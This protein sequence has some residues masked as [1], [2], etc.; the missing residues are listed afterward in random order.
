MTEPTPDVVSFSFG[1]KRNSRLL[2]NLSHGIGFIR[3]Y[4]RELRYTTT[5][6]W[7]GTLSNPIPYTSYTVRPIYLGLKLHGP[8]AMSDLILSSVWTWTYDLVPEHNMSN[9]D[10]KPMQ[11]SPRKEMR[12]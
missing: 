12:Y 2:G 10:P 9:H 11:V 7:F 6:N 8:E 3:I 1:K 5:S 4:H